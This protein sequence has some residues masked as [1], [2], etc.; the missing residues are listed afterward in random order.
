MPHFGDRKYLKIYLQVVLDQK[1][2]FDDLWGEM[3]LVEI[4]VRLETFLA[5]GKCQPTLGRRDGL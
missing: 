5:Y 3:L 1:P 2:N 4:E